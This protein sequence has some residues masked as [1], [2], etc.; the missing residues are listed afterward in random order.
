MASMQT[1]SLVSGNFAVFAGFL[2][3]RNDDRDLR[4]PPGPRRGRAVQPAD[5]GP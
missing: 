5:I 1:F 3:V 4:G 2:A